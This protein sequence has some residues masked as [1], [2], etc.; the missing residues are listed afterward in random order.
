MPRSQV[1]GQSPAP[2]QPVEPVEE[3]PGVSVTRGTRPSIMSEHHAPPIGKEAFPAGEQPR[4]RSHHPYMRLALMA[5]I[6]FIVMYFLMY[7]MV[8]VT[9]NVFNSLNQV[10]MAG[11]MTAP[12]VLIELALMHRMY[13]NA[14]LNVLWAVLALLAGIFF[15]LGIR[16]QT[17]I[18]NEQ[19]LRSMIPHHAG[20]LL[21]CE[22][23]PVTD[24][25]IQALC[26]QIIAGQQREI[27]QMKQLLATPQ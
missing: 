17:A 10:Y 21:M 7:A 15:W 9:A 25:R 12:M 24:E 19:F 14:R 26:Q 5:L 2:P 18:G 6:S 3:R 23:A 1:P 11:L 4:A 27:D 22:K 16:T 20:A 13:G 8:D